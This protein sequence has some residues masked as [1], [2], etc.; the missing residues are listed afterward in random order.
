MICISYFY[1]LL[2]N[3]VFSFTPKSHEDVE[4]QVKNALIGRWFFFDNP[5]CYLDIT[6]DSIISG[7]IYDPEEAEMSAL[8]FRINGPIERCKIGDNIFDFV[9]CKDV[10]VELFETTLGG[11][12]RIHSVDYIDRDEMQI[13]MG[14]FSSGLVKDTQN[15]ENNRQTAVHKYSKKIKENSLYQRE[16]LV[17]WYVSEASTS[18]VKKRP[19][20]NYDIPYLEGSAVY[21]DKDTLYISM[22]NGF[23]LSCDDT[24]LIGDLMTMKKMEKDYLSIQ[25]P[26]IEINC[27]HVS[28]GDHIDDCIIGEPFMNLLNV[29]GDYVK[30]YPLY[31]KDG[32]GTSCFLF[33]VDEAEELVLYSDSEYLL[34]RLRQQ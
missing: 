22:V 14:R 16:S 6:N 20:D 2:L 8:E 3:S 26:G 27:I 17:R 5:S 29:T 28:R 23:S 21:I 9:H 32:G 19:K 34:L 31:K 13:S 7:N 24:L 4:A 15:I 10:G 33:V 1:I 12:I 25:Y 30:G 18:H 11:Y